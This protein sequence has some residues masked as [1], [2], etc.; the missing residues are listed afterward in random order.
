MRLIR[1]N[2]DASLQGVYPSK[3]IPQHI[4]LQVAYPPEYALPACHP[5]RTPNDT[6]DLKRL[7]V[8]TLDSD[9]PERIHGE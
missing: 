6:A 9:H 4:R 3:R 2:S 8:Q 5:S 7:W 1:Q